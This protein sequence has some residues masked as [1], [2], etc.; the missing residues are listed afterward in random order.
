MNKPW[1][2]SRLKRPQLSIVGFG[3]VGSRL[4]EHLNGRVKMLALGRQASIVKGARFIAIDLDQRKSLKR[5]LKLSK[6]A[7]YLAPPP[8][9][10]HDDARIR[11]FL[12]AA[13]GI[14]RCVYVSTTAVYGAAHGAWTIVPAGGVR[15]AGDRMRPR[16]R[17]DVFPE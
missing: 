1:K 12:T 4:A 17:S 15:H 16:R 8:A 11:R 5:A 3:D 6:W 10:G 13:S 7:V 9:S 2:T 14:E